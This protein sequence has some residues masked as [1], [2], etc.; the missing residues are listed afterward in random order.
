MADCDAA[1]RELEDKR[2]Q[3]LSTIGVW[4][5]AGGL[6]PRPSEPPDLVEVEQRIGRLQRDS[7]AARRALPDHEAVQAA[8][9]RHDLESTARRDRALKT[10]ILE[11]VADYLDRRYVAAMWEARSHEA[12]AWNVFD[13]LDKAGDTDTARRC[14]ELIRGAKLL[15]RCPPAQPEKG[16]AFIAALLRDPASA[17][18]GG[19]DA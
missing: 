15:L 1:E 16:Q 11:S 13:A 17:Q 9:H 8:A 2:Q 4:L 10:A 14:V 19:D 18:I 7:A 5:G 6:P 3:F 12:A